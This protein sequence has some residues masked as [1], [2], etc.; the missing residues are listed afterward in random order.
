MHSEALRPRD[1]PSTGPI[2]PHLAHPRRP[3]PRSSPLLPSI[4][5]PL[6][7]KSPLVAPQTPLSMTRGLPTLHQLMPQVRATSSVAPQVSRYARYEFPQPCRW[8]HE[9]L[10][11][12]G[13]A[14]AI[15]LAPFMRLTRSHLTSIHT[16]THSPPLFSL[17][18]PLRFRISFGL[19][20][21]LGPQTSIELTAAWAYH[22][23]GIVG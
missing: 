23:P 9:C 1:V 5:T 15:R 4:P 21:R 3:S 20:T 17:L 16:R 13:F 10:L 22:L 18:L 2:T 19:Q 7:L 8:S 11:R 14:F 6:P 12:F